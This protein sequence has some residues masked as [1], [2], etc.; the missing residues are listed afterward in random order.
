MVYSPHPPYELLFN[1]DLDF[2]TM[3]RLRRFARYWDLVGNSG[4]FTRTTQIICDA[5]SPFRGF[6]KFSDW[7]YAQEKRTHG[8]SLVCLAERVFEYLTA[9]RKLPAAEVAAAIWEDYSRTGRKD[10]PSFL[11]GYE[12]TS[13][14]KR[15]SARRL[16]PRQARHADVPS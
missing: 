5:D 1:R 3:H 7:L 14:M 10:R 4:N 16:P 9:V 6:M 15:I 12:L 2:V 13:P 11:A 8:I